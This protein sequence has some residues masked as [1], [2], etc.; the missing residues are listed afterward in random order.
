MGIPNEQPDDPDDDTTADD[1]GGEAGRGEWGGGLMNELDNVR[2]RVA[3][4]TATQDDC[5][6]LLCLADTLKYNLFLRDLEKPQDC[7]LMPVY[8]ACIV[9]TWTTRLQ[10]ARLLWIKRS[11]LRTEMDT[12]YHAEKPAER[13]AESWEKDRQAKYIAIKVQF[14]ATHIRL[15]RLCERLSDSDVKAVCEAENTVCAKEAR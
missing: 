7:S 12:I 6:N 11:R 4:G 15:A 3:E 10:R 2:R 9:S 1:D 5:F 8:R 13:S 14:D